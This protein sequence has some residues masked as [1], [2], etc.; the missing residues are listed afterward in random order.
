M[1][2]NLCFENA[3]TLSILADPTPLSAP[4]PL[5]LGALSC[6]HKPNHDP[7][8]L[9]HHTLLFF[10]GIISMCIDAFIYL[11]PFFPSILQFHK[12]RVL[13]LSR[14]L[15]THT[16]VCQARCLS[17]GFLQSLPPPATFQSCTHLYDTLLY[18]ILLLCQS[19]STRSELLDTRAI[20]CIP[21]IAKHIPSTP[22]PA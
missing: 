13:A 10:I 22:C 14:R 18:S 4:G 21:S 6:L 19:L 12:D 11:M 15:R 17:E 1:H 2:T 9:F 8:T 16:N 20:P 7:V 3:G 5:P